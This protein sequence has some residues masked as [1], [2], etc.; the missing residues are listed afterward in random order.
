MIKFF[1]ELFKIE[2]K[3]RKNL[4]ALEWVVM[5]YLL[6]TLLLI[7]F[8]S[9]KLYNPESMIWGRVRIAVMTIALWGVYRMLPCRFTRFVRVLAQM[10][11]LSWWYPDT[12]EL[13]RIF[14]NLD[15]LFAAWEQ[16][17]FGCQP[18]LLF[19]KAVPSHI[20]S[21]LMDMG[22]AAYFPMIVAVILYYFVKEYKQ[23]ERASFIV[24]ASFFIYY[25]IFVLVP[26]TGPQYYYH[27]VGIDDI[28]RGIFPNLHDYFATHQEHLVSPGYTDGYFY[29]IVADAHRAGERPTAAFPSSHVGIATVLM[30]LAWR[31]RN[32]RF[33]YIL[34]PFFVLLCL[35]TVYIQAHYLI[36]A[37]AGL[38]T[39]AI[40][41]FVLLF[42]SRDMQ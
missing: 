37:I 41:Y 21:E 32:R 25:V 42:L 29:Q 36:D 17:I 2:K 19:S 24:I 11:L 6:F 12:Y 20:F 33:F 14:P 23:F 18:A 9:T 27:A 13:N 22:Y 38:V 16:T 3:P 26:V 10:S 28:A 40:L 30:F 15:H 39:G 8:A 4:F 34:L 35:A 31:T 7:M 1:K 5:G